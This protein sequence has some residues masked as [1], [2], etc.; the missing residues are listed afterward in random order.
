MYP[1]ISV[2]LWFSIKTAK[3]YSKPETFFNESRESDPPA[4]RKGQTSGGEVVSM[5]SGGMGAQYAAS[6][7][8]AG[9]VKL[10]QAAAAREGTVGCIN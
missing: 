8:S 3:L 1:L 6:A 9:D 5:R 2:R 4:S 10:R 7:K